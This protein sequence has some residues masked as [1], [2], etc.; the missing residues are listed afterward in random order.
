MA[1]NG[2]TILIVEDDISLLKA[3]VAKFSKE[4]FE[5]LEAKNGKQG[6]KAAID[7]KPDLILLDIVMP[8]MDG[9]SMLEELRKDTWGKDAA[10]IILSNLSLTEKAVDIEEYNALQYLIKSDWSLEEIVKKVKELL[11]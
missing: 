11:K 7:N 2:K 10:V 5:C 3:L 1:K 4:G 9:I 6:L 8:R